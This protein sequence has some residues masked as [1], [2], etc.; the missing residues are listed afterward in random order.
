[1]SDLTSADTKHGFSGD[2]G[3]L[4]HPDS[5]VLWDLRAKQVEPPKVLELFS[6]A[7]KDDLSFN[8]Q[9]L[10]RLAG[11]LVD[12]ANEVEGKPPRSVPWTE[13]EDYAW[14]M[15]ICQA[16]NIYAFQKNLRWLA[17]WEYPGWI[18]LQVTPRKALAIG[19]D[20]DMHSWSFNA[21]IL[22][23]EGENA[24]WDEASNAENGIIEIDS[25]ITIPNARQVAESIIKYLHEEL[26]Y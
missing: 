10:R 25:N 8:P 19:Y 16:L 15:N 6:T 13:E 23:G 4:V 18:S 26:G 24:I 21:S 5:Y 22:R 12:T 7:F 9:V 11:W 3:S 1:M 2:G 17:T 20:S 14:G